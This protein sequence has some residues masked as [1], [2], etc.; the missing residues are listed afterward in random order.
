M[1]NLFQVLELTRCHI[2]GLDVALCLHVSVVLDLFS[3]FYLF[4]SKNSL[5]V[6]FFPAAI[7]SFV[8]FKFKAVL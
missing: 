8:K 2:S 7:F 6:R 4:S 1:F 3:L 5:Y